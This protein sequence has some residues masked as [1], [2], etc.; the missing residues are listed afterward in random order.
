MKI[1]IDRNVLQ[2]ALSHAQSVVERRASIPILSNVLL[3]A[4]GTQL[5]L[6]ATDMDLEIVEAVEVQVWR[7]GAV[8]LPAHTLYDIVRKLPADAS[9]EIDASK[10][11]QA[12]I[13]AGRSTFRLG[14]LPIEDFPK[15]ETGD[16]RHQ[17]KLPAADLRGMI[18][19]TRFAISTEETRFYLNG[20]FLHRCDTG[21]RAAATDGHRLA[22]VERDA[23]I[24][25]LDMP[26]IIVPRKTVGEVRGLLDGITGDVSVAVSDTKI[27]VAAG[28]VVITSKLIDGIFPDYERVIP[29]GNDKV[30]EINPKALA[31]AVSRVSIV[32]G[33]NCRAVK[34]TLTRGSLVL[35][36]SNPDGGSAI[37][38]LDVSYG[39]APLEVGFNGRYLLDVL[40]QVAGPVIRF[41]MAD[42][43]AP[44]IVTDP[45]DARTLYV[46]MPMRV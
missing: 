40:G 7:K 32:S 3:R 46:L 30:L 21:L 17:F 28:S 14:C 23:P 13:K 39:S 18:D 11:A 9:I 4:A 10:G 38:E 33:D 20:I 29:T 6:T 31:D 27:R 34:L 35:A 42:A 25:T 26:G 15:F 1:T 43:A 44:T 19:R 2:G 5:E 37:E 24:G 45:E 36:A 41:T 12:T 22:R 8:T 16:M